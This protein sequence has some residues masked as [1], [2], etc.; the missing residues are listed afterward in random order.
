MESLRGL[1]SKYKEL[2]SYVFWGAATTVVN[3]AVY[4][5]CTRLLRI[6]P[7]GSNV[8]A[9]VVSVAFAF[10]VNKWLVFAARSL[11]RAAVL[12]ELWRFV[13]ARV[14][15]GG[16]ETLLL[17]VFVSVLRCPDAAVKI[18]VSVLVVIMNYVLSKWIIFKKPSQ[19]GDDP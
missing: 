18:A 12:R 5:S 3:Y 13:S 9:W 1:L 6:D 19:P 8:I 17:F 2:I 10:V 4:F 14:L 16:L 11:E 15:S 7:V